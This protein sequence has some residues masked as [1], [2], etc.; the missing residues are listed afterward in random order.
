MALS[1]DVKDWNA[2]LDDN[3]REFLAHI[4]RFFTQ[5]DID[6]ADG[7]ISQ[8]LPY[9][10]PVEVR[11]M[12]AAFANME[13]V[14]IDAYALLIE[15]LGM[16]EIEF[17]KFMQYK[18]MRDKHDWICDRANIADNT[19]PI[20][21]LLTIGAYG[22]LTEG[23]QLFASFAMLLNFPR[24]NKMKNMGQV[25]T[26]SVRDESLH[27]EGISRLFKTYAMENKIN[28]NDKRIKERMVAETERA[29][30]FED[31]FIDLAFSA[32]GIKGLTANEVKLYI[33]YIADW[34]L[35]QFG[36]KQNL[37]GIENH[38]LPWLLSILNGVEHA[39]FFETRATE[40][41]KGATVGDWNDVWNNYKFELD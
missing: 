3:E 8:Y 40:Y 14:H 1:E 21:T 32:G 23:L 33:R 27:C 22:A 35:R 17:S 2:K 4:F 24:Q 13:S 38:P 26:W 12:L 18:E 6:V 15:T 30:Y 7:Y 31:K 10:K 37:Y 19:D 20:D 9:F 39:N 28:L 34:R 29:I 16:P 11:M 36:F 5:S 41:S 25:I